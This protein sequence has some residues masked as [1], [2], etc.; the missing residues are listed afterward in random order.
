MSSA[1]KLKRKTFGISPD[2]PSET[3]E[4][5]K[6]KKKQFKEA[7]KDSKTVFFQRV[8]IDGVEM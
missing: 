4:R 3:L 6:K 7:K 2:L 8:F 1:R 5:G